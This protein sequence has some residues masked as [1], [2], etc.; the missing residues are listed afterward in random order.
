MSR[1]DSV[2][3]S[4]SYAADADGQERS[5]VQLCPT[6]LDLHIVEDSARTRLSILFPTVPE[7]FVIPSGRDLFI[8]FLV[9]RS[10]FGAIRHLELPL[11]RHVLFG[12]GLAS[13]VAV[14]LEVAVLDEVRAAI[15]S[16][17][18]AVERWHIK[19][20]F[21]VAVEVPIP[22]QPAELRWRAV[23]Q[24]KMR[25]PAV[26]WLVSELNMNLKRY[27]QLA[28]T[29]IPEA[30]VEFEELMSEVHETADDLL[31][32]ERDAGGGTGNSMTPIERKRRWDASVDWLV[33]ANSS[34]IYAITQAFHG[35][36]PSRFKRGLI[37]PHSLTGTGTAWRAIFRL[38]LQIKSAF[39]SASLPWAI[40]THFIKLPPFVWDKLSE[41]TATDALSLAPPS[42]IDPREFGMSAKIVHFSSRLGFGETDTSLTC[43]AQTLQTCDSPQ[44]SLATITHEMLH[45][46]VRDL[47]A[48]IFT[49]YNGEEPLSFNESVLRSIEEFES[50]NDG[51]NAGNLL[52]SIRFA[53]IDYSFVYRNALEDFQKYHPSR[54]ENDEHNLDISLPNSEKALN[55]FLRANKFTEEVIIHVLD[56]LYFYR[57]DSALF[58]DSLW[59]TWA[60][61]PSTVSK[62]DWYVLRTLLSLASTV[63]G[64]EFAR[65][66]QASRILVDRLKAMEERGRGV[67]IVREVIDRLD[68]QTRFKHW[69]E[70]LFPPTIKIVDVARRILYHKEVAAE[71]VKTT[72]PLVQLEGYQL[73]PESFDEAGVESPVAL[74]FDRLRR[75]AD[76]DEELDAIKLARSSCAVLLAASSDPKK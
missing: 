4:V 23:E 42:D 29:Y 11:R 25:D 14:S 50:A 12:C 58:V 34:L 17:L 49:H 70:L 56:L 9:H 66:E 15:S 1:V 8:E 43:P 57:G 61:V 19:E 54:V 18:I 35:A 39:R 38:Y 2:T 47:F 65:L 60:T 44:W 69:L 26:R 75:S 41:Y 37:T 51:K 40:E 20:G 74:I 16:G 64:N 31:C 59:N 10:P 28:A 33:Q 63:D 52:E 3:L 68:N 22:A 55:A 7:R 13:I 6:T 76:G 73:E 5:A 36:L 53:L 46:H 27:G 24:M 48:A 71:L 45:S 30:M 21:I 32:L 72:D 62:L 67:E